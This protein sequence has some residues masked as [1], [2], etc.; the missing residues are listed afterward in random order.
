ML[1]GDGGGGQ[2]RGR[3]DRHHDEQ[4]PSTPAVPNHLYHHHHQRGDGRVPPPPSSF[5]AAKISPLRSSARR[6]NEKGGGGKSSIAT[7]T[8]TTASFSVREKTPPPPPPSGGMDS[9]RLSTGWCLTPRTP[10]P[11][12][13]EYRVGG[14]GGGGGCARGGAPT[15]TTTMTT[16]AQQHLH[17]QTPCRMTPTN[18]ASD[19]G[20]AHRKE[21]SMNALDVSNVY[22]WLHSPTG[23]GLFTPSGGLNSLSVTNT[24]RGMYGFSASDNINAGCHGPPKLAPS[25]RHHSQG[26]FASVELEAGGDVGVNTPK[27]P[28]SQRS[29]ICISPLASR[30]SGKKGGHA[31]VGGGVEGAPDT[32]MSINFSEVFASPRLPTPRLRRTLAPF[33]SRAEDCAPSSDSRQSSPVASALHSAERDINLDD[34]LNA[35]LQ[36]AETATPGG[37]PSMAF[38]SPLLTNSLRT[39]SDA[40]RN[41][42]PPS[43]LQLPIIRGSS[44]RSSGSGATPPQLAIRSM[45]S[46]SAPPIKSSLKS[47]SKKRKL[48]DGEYHGQEQSQAGYTQ[49]SMMHYRHPLAANPAPA[50]TDAHH[51]YYHHPG[52]GSHHGCAYTSTDHHAPQQHYAYP[53]QPPPAS[54]SG[55]P[56]DAPSPV[57]SSKKSKSRSKSKS[58]TKGK[59][60]SPVPSGAAPKRVRKSSPK[61]GVDKSFPDCDGA[62]KKSKNSVSDPADKER[63]TAAIIAVNSVYGDGSEKERKLKEVTLRGVTQRPSKKWQAQLYYAGK[64]RYIGVFDSKE[65][66]SLA[67]EI[68]REVLKTDKDEHGP[69]NAEETE[70]NVCLARKAAFA[71]INEHTCPE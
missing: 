21:G 59:A 16:D 13:S 69:S 29:M 41:G 62:P 47:K 37:R 34:D 1:K 14:I 58:S 22:A 12:P 71:G 3:S 28:D 11:P 15:T 6:N 56:I 66:A 39:A 48:P 20:R 61:V 2:Q 70:R 4:C 49:P 54:T 18:F 40:S 25:P 33:G 7:A 55:S 64:S 51:G 53:D 9:A 23:Q 36:L 26:Y 52:Y 17:L 63:I 46:G 32:P 60:A 24:P 42:D 35:L 30:R 57:V 43:S 31:G 68:A 45:S 19:F 10:K 50:V 27:I 8:T 5:L 67:Y 65:K 44:V 38:M